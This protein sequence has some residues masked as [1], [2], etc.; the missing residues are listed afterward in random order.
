MFTDWHLL[1]VPAL[2]ATVLVFV[3]SS[4]I[5]MVIQWH[6]PDYKKF[7]NEDEVRAAIRKSNAAPGE[8]IL[9]HCKDGKE[10]AD[11]AMQKKFEEGP[12]GVVYLRANG[13]TK[14][15]PF[16]GAWIVYT[17]VISLLV[18]YV[19]WSVLPRG[20]SY[21]KV[22]QVIGATAWLAYAWGGPSDSIW[23]GKPWMA[24]FRGLV[25]GLV[26][27]SLTAGA[28]AWLWPD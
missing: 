16:L 6:A 21:L 2:V 27:A 9:P 22:F 4:I 18:A 13:A 19:G 15:G 1:F 14:L 10:M 3:A 11:P 23:K 25:D 7:S 5:H 24:T 8:Y 28:F 17:F 12:L 26:Y 20:A